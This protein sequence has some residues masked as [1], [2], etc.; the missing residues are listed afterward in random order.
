[1]KSL[2]KRVRSQ[3]ESRAGGEAIEDEEGLGGEEFVEEGHHN[4]WHHTHES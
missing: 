2:Y 1:M 4:G 3:E